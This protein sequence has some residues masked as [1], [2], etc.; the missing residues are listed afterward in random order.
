[1]ALPESEETRVRLLEQ[2]IIYR[3]DK[4]DEPY[5]PETSPSVLELDRYIAFVLESLSD[6]EEGKA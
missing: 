4:A 5:E 2:L 6:E 3:R 1:M